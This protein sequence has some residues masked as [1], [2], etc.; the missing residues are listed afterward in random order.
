MQVN[1][2]DPVV[3]YAKSCEGFQKGSLPE[4]FWELYQ[5]ALERIIKR[6]GCFTI[7][8]HSTIFICK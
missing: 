1:D 6:E 5:H 4:N 2:P 7:T 8:K 3:A